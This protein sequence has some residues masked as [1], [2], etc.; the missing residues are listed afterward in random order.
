M[1]MS[2]KALKN[3]EFEV[4]TP[5]QLST[6]VGRCPEPVKDPSGGDY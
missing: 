6:L 5:L 3:E 4:K 2:V 1:K